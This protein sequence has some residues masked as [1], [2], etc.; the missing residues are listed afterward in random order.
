MCA[1]VYVNVYN[2]LPM[3]VCCSVPHDHAYLFCYYRLFS[4]V[5][6]LYFNIVFAH[7]SG[8]IFS[9]KQFNLAFC[10][11]FDSIECNFIYSSTALPKVMASYQHSF[12]HLNLF[13]KL[14]LL[15]LY[16]K[17]C[18]PIIVLICISPRHRNIQILIDIV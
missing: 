4:F 18:I 9:S 14:Q 13:C 17:A 6:I 5:F 12:I 16:S 7:L 11:I 1:C 10:Y 8:A 15:P 3:R 2:F